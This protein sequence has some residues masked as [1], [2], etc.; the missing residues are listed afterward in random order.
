[1]ERKD[2]LAMKP[3]ILI[4]EDEA[5]IVADWKVEFLERDKY[6]L[7]TASN[8]I[9]AENLLTRHQFAMVFIDMGLPNEAD[10][11][12]DN[13]NGLSLLKMAKKMR[14]PVCALTGTNNPDLAQE[15]GAARVPMIEKPIRDFEKEV[16]E[17]IRE[18]T[19]NETR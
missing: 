7:S 15:I 6:E 17:R 9:D 13:K 10:G 5:S 11:I 4:I 2:D 18:V 1:M 12:A 3:K 19:E 8:R 14:L 16:I